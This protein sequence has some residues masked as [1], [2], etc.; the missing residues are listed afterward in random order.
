MEMSIPHFHR[1]IYE[2]I[3]TLIDSNFV[4]TAMREPGATKEYL[5]QLQPTD[6]V[7]PANERIPFCWVVK[8]K[9][10]P[11]SVASVL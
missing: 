9:K 5:E 4:I 8:A 2:Y 10:T 11:E 3:E 1:P 6:R 7:W